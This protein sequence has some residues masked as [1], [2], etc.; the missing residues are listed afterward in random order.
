MTKAAFEIVLNIHTEDG[1]RRLDSPQSVRDL[2][3]SGI[4]ND[5]VEEEIDYSLEVKRIHQPSQAAQPVA[6]PCIGNDPTCPC[7]DGDACHYRGEN[8]MSI[9]SAHQGQPVASPLVSW[10][11]I[12][13]ELAVFWQSPYGHGKEKIASFWWPYHPVEKTAE[14]E[15]L[16][17]AI[18]TRMTVDAAPTTSLPVASLTALEHKIDELAQ[19]V[20]DENSG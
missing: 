8:A 12:G 10:E 1:E 20:I 9:P 19:A 14:V 4:D 2:I 16:F 3:A 17:E 13:E 11:Y 18:A 5:S 7:Q 6:S 15:A